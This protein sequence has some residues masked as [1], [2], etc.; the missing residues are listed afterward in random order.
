MEK[1]WASLVVQKIKFHLQCRRPEFN[2]WVGKIPLRKAWH[3]TPLFFPG[4]P[5]GQRS[6]A[7][8]SPWGSRIGHY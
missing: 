4:E 5:H 7:S 8:Y 2:P 6:L 1:D 3:P